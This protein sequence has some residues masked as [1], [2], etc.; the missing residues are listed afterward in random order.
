MNCSKILSSER[1][2]ISIVEIMA[3]SNILIVLEIVTNVFSAY[4]F[5]NIYYFLIK[6]F[7]I[8]LYN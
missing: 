6:R 8:Y 5:L 3:L 4:K 2:Q 1:M 7:L